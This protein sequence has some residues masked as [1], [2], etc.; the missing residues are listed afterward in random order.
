MTQQ[1][2][3]ARAQILAKNFFYFLPCIFSSFSLS[4]SASCFPLYS[5]IFSSLNHQPDMC[6]IYLRGALLVVKRPN[7]CA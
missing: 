1:K 7:R 5:K 4:S 6:S 3:Q 2:I